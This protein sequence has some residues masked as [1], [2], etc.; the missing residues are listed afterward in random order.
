MPHSYGLRARTRH[1]FA[2]PFRRHGM[3]SLSTYL[4]TYKVGDY[5]DIVVNG[6]VHKGMPYRFYHGRTGRVWN[7]GKHSVGVEVNK[8]VSNRL[9]RKRLVVRIEHVRPSQCQKEFLERKKAYAEAA[10]L[11]GEAR[12]RGDKELP[13]LPPK[14]RLPEQPKPGELVE[15]TE[16]VTLTPAKFVNLF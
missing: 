7:I 16:V 5:V 11:R 15:A 9:V 10:R 4:H 2:R 12:K 1:M 13:P 3:P 8:Q 6:A 14:R